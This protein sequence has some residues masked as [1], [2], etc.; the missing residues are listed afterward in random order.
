VRRRA[1]PAVLA[2]ACAASTAWAVLLPGSTSDSATTSA[3]RAPVLSARR[4]PAFLARAVADTRLRAQLDA[5]LADPRLG[6][7]RERSCL[8]VRHGARPVL[9]RREATAL[10]PASNMKL[11]TAIAVLERLGPDQRLVTE[12]RAGGAVS[13]E[14]VV[15][16][17]LWM[18]GGGDPLLGT[19]DYAASFENQPQVRTPV[20]ALADAVV[21]AGVRVVQ[22]PVVGDETRYDTQR[23][24]PTWKPGYATDFESGPASALVV[25]DGFE[26]FRPRRVAAPEPDLH[27]AA[28]LVALLQARGV[29]VAGGAA[30]GQAPETATVVARTESPPMRDVVGEML[31]ESDN[32]TAELLV[33]ELGR[34]FAG[35]GTTAAGL[36][37]VRQSLEAAG[38]PVADLV[39]VDGSGL[40]RSDRATCALLLAALD[41]TGPTGPVATGLPVAA[42]DGTLAKRF[43]GNPAAGRLRAKTGS[44]DGVVGLAGYVDAIDGGTPLSFALM[45]NDLPRDA[46]GRALQE[47]VGAI[48][49]AYPEAPAPEALA[50]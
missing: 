1:L 11:L 42:R 24:I 27:A 4:A 22:G 33:K 38:L 47:Q 16:G 28:T 3:V 7:A 15:A 36:G 13:P 26:Q 45:A 10:I 48:L 19:A 34:R 2:L 12:V 40:D 32:L 23:Y 43:Q 9:G 5:A 21:A 20:E 37:V 46:L 41:K 29:T 30:E 35:A 6:A 8:V 44:L 50:P 39:N 49:A 31:R 17:P 14:G 18:V 25:N